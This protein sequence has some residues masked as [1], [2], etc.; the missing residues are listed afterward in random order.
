MKNT[1]NRLTLVGLAS[2][3]GIRETEVP[4]GRLELPRHLE[5]FTDRRIP[6]PLPEFK[7]RSR[8]FFSRPC[9]TYQWR[10]PNPGLWSEPL[11]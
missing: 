3:V 4:Q 8:Y 10:M 11:E 6:D 5:I 1:P 9:G 7:T 2:W